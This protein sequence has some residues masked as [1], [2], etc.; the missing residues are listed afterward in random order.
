MNAKEFLHVALG[1]NMNFGTLKP[2]AIEEIMEQ[3]ARHKSQ[4][5]PEADVRL[6]DWLTALEEGECSLVCAPIL[7]GEVDCEV[8]WLVADQQD[9]HI[10]QGSSPTEALENAFGC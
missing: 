2:L 8:I 9:K 6:N 7:L 1:G 4:E 10:G 5:T 3:Y